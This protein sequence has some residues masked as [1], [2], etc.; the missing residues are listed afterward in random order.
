VVGRLG[1]DEFSILSMA[2][3]EDATTLTHRLSKAVS[4]YNEQS[5][6]PYSMS[7]AIGSADFNPRKPETLTEL[8]GRADVVMFENKKHRLPKS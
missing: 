5:Y 2:G 3:E 8:V 1:S 6:A 7:T 4:E